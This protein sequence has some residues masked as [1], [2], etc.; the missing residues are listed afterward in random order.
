MKK[1]L[2]PVQEDI[3]NTSGNIIVKASAGTGK[4]HTMVTKIEKDIADNKSHKVIAA[5]TFTIRAA[6]EIRDRLPAISED[7]FIGTN[8]SFAI[9]EIIKPF[10]KDVYGRDYDKE[11]GTDYEVKVEDFDEGID[12]I[13][14]SGIIASLKDN[15]ENFIFKLALDIV[16]NSFACREFLKAKYFNIYV[17]EYQDCDKDMHAFLCICVM[18]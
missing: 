3:V 12:E 18:S 14:E 7:H 8:N 17:D 10:M 9:E 16:K 13:K 5:I 15:K 6:G 4:T 11:M 2:S 1:P